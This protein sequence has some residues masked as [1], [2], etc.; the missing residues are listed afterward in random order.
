MDLRLVDHELLRHSVH[1]KEQ[2]L[3]IETKIR[4][5]LYKESLVGVFEI[6]AIF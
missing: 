4:N 6:E 3:G 5:I 1:M 2:K